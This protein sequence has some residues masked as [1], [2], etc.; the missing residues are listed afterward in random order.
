MSKQNLLVKQK[1][2]QQFLA[3]SKRLFRPT[4]AHCFVYVILSGG[5]FVGGF[6]LRALCPGDSVR[7][8]FVRDSVQG[9]LYGGLCPG[10][11][12]MDSVLGDFVR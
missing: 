6:S 4:S 3:T 11:M 7:G 9:I 2:N 8:D 10:I 5:D 12:S 1:Y